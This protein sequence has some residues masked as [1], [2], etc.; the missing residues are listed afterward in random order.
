[1]ATHY[2]VL[3][4]RPD[5]S[6]TQIRSAFVQKARDLHPDGHAGRPDADIDTARRAMQDVNEAWRVLRDPALRAAYDRLL[7]EAPTQAKARVAHPATTPAD[8]AL[9][10]PYPRRPAEPGDVTVA[11]VRAAPWV[12][13]LVVLGVIFVFTAFAKDDEAE[14]RT[15]IGKCVSTVS[16][17]ALEVPC[18]APNDGVVVD[19]VQESSGCTGG[20]VAEVV[21]G[22]TWYCLRPPPSE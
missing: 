19:I 14:R 21:P 22:G 2:D 6:T 4:V 3:G 5:A 8:G 10:R 7:Q 16:G 11:L 1:M 17:P 18:S 15:L 9:D 20:A 12:A 13:V